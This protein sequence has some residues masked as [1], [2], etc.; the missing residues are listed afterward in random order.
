MDNKLVKY[1]K[2]YGKNLDKDGVREGKL[3][4]GLESEPCVDK[5]LNIP[6]IKI[7]LNADTH[8]FCRKLIVQFLSSLWQIQH[9]ARTQRR[10]RLYSS[11]ILL[12]YD[13]RR[14]RAH[15]K[16]RSPTENTDISVTTTPHQ[17]TQLN[18]VKQGCL[19]R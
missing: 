7:F 11:S 12:I 10:F 19:Y 17:K 5:L 4:I 8:Y 18:L 3:V 13:A 14:L 16:L 2:T 9:F 1:D 15:A 6:A